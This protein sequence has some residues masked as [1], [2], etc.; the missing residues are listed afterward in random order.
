[1]RAADLAANPEIA[2]INPIVT[3]PWRPSLFARG[4][5]RMER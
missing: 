2:S 5:R 1:M 4:R 3:Y